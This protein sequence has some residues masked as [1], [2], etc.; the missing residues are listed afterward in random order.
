M[1]Q[2]SILDNIQQ[3][4]DFTYQDEVEMTP[5]NLMVAIR[6]LVKCDLALETIESGLNVATPGSKYQYYRAIFLDYED[7]IL[8]QKQVL[9]TLTNV[10]D[11]IIQ[12][13][14]NLLEDHASWGKHKITKGID[15]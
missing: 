3:I 8:E 4:T 11:E 9:E 2:A 10:P 15:V 6:L 13:V 12:Q 7:I 1:L 14:L 5:A